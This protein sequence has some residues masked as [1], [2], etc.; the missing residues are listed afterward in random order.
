M[1]RLIAIESSVAIESNTSA[2]VKNLWLWTLKLVASRAQ[3]YRIK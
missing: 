2:E 1:Y 3:G